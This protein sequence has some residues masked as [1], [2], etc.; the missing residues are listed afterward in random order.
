MENKKAQ[1]EVIT[2]VLIILLVLAAVFIVYTAVT[3][4]IRGSTKTAGEKSGCLG[5]E[6]EITSATGSLTAGGANVKITRSAGG[7]ADAATPV[8]LVNGVA[9]ST[10][11][12]PNACSSAT[13]KELESTTCTFTGALAAGN[14][15]SV[16][17]KIGTTACDISS[18]KMLV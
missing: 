18:T 6:L 15:V 5:T 9:S 16:A 14:N 11:S 10:T 4:M 12:N 3:G 1:S 2:T 13:L 7:S 8:I 17:S